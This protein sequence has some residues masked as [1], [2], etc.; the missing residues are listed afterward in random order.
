MRRAA[1]IAVATA[2]LLLVGGTAHAADGIIDLD[3]N[4]T[5]LDRNIQPLEKTSTSGDEE[6]VTLNSDILFD[7]GKSSLDDAAGA[8]IADLVEDVPK[9]GTVHVDGHTDSVPYKRGN[10]V[11]SKERAQAVA[12]AIAEARPDLKLKVAGHGDSEPVAPNSS[13]GKDDPEGR[14][15]N[16][17][18]EIRY[19][20]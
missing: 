2:I 18:V 14:A 3:P 15:K 13:G 8:K 19:D 20:G 5:S 10:D 6:V 16:R 17:R 1:P 7:F 12:D 11:L 9:K 4:V